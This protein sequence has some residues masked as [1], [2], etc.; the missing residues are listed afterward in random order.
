MKRT[1]LVDLMQRYITGQV[2]AEEKKKIEAWLD[3]KKNDDGRDMLLSPEDEERLFRQLTSS[4]E[5]AEG[6][7]AFRPAA[8]SS[9]RWLAIAASLIVLIM[10]AYTVWF[11]SSHT[12]DHQTITTTQA[13]KTILDDGSIVWL[14]KASRLTYGNYDD[15]R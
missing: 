9:K 4:I 14:R 5:N 8:R 2:T 3:V 6:I 15:V 7:K 11:F 12:G 1:N 10:S 13:E